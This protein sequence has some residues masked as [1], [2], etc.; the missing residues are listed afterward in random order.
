MTIGI[1]VTLQA[2]GSLLL[3]AN[4]DTRADLA[5]AL[6]DSWDRAEGDFME[7]VRG[8]YIAA[9][10][11]AKGYGYSL[12]WLNPADIFALT[13]MPLLADTVTDDDGATRV[14]G[15]VW[16]FPDHQVISYLAELAHKGRVVFA[17]VANYGDGMTFPAR[18]GKDR[19]L[20]DRI[21]TDAY[22]YCLDGEPVVEL[23]PDAH[24]DDGATIARLVGFRPATP[25]PV[26]RP[27][28]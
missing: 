25:A 18:W 22:R 11:P 14:Y 12:E 3:Q 1:K 17:M 8:Q 15:P 6:K 2:D 16:G 23:V 7:M 5:H 19:A 9:T 24:G 13:D 28:L 27:L 21:A 4:N 26:I 20:A 10:E